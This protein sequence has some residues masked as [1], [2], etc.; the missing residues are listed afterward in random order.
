MQ[1]VS[2]QPRSLFKHSLLIQPNTSKEIQYTFSTRKNNVR[3]GIYFQ[4]SEPL[5]RA[6]TSVPKFKLADSARSSTS[7]S[8]QTNSKSFQ[9]LMDDADLVPVFPM[10]HY[11]SSKMQIT[12]TFLA[13]EPGNYFLVFDNTFSVYAPFLISSQENAKETLFFSLLQGN[14]T[15]TVYR[16]QGN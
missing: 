12:G 6:Q 3:F 5:A 13:Q 2:I 14:S 7:P 8:L 11:Q 1:E 4:R 15:S 10:A 9:E 16:A